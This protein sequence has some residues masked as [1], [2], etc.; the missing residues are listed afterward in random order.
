MT[1]KCTLDATDIADFECVL[2]G[3]GN[4]LRSHK[5][6]EAKTYWRADMVE[7]LCRQALLAIELE[8]DARRYRWLRE[9]SCQTDSN[10]NDAEE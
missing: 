8:R 5:N 6:G 9:H 4:F 1:T 7:L 10:G 2:H 3:N